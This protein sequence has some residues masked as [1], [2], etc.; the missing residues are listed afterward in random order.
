M[1]TYVPTES[2]PGILGGQGSSGELDGIQAWKRG[3][4]EKESKD[5]EISIPL[6]PKPSADQPL[7]TAPPTNPEKP[8]NEIQLFKLLMKKEQETKR[9]DSVVDPNFPDTPTNPSLQRQ[10]DAA[11]GMKTSLVLFWTLSDI[12]F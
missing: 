7:P 6:P 3:L 8:L 12:F 10:R 4:K 11:S 5:K 2:T 1:D 9:P